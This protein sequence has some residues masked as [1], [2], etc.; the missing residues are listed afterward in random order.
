[1]VVLLILSQI[2]LKK[3]FYCFLYIFLFLA[4]TC[5]RDVGRIDNPK[6]VTKM[7]GILEKICL[8]KKEFV[9]IRKLERSFLETESIARGADAPRGFVRAL[10]DSISSSDYALITEIKKASPSRG[11]IRKDFEPSKLAIAYEN[12]GATCLSVLTDVPYFQGDDSYLVTAR[13]AVNLPVLRKDFI[14]DIY[15][16]VETRALGAD[17][18]LLIMAA[19]DDTQAEEL[20]ACSLELGMDV[21]IEIHDQTELDRALRLS[22]PLIGINNRN[23]KTLEVD[24]AVTKKLA[25]HIPEGRLIVS[26]SGIY[27]P[28]D[29]EVLSESGAR[30]FLIG[31]SLM[32]QDDVMLATSIL[33]QKNSET[34]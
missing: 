19:L 33:L 12:G 32:R 23:L 29:L 3:V 2:A 13:N 10:L 18:I 26:E 9:R 7:N 25:P 6:D 5:V 31:E 1:L 15:Q 21:L 4:F 27:T 22:S 17:C 20:E 11:I 24:M 30:C 14:L 16:V 8:D 34:H 28:A